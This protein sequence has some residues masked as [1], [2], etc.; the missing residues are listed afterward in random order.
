DE[1][2]YR[3]SAGDKAPLAVLVE[4]PARVAAEVSLYDGNKKLLAKTRGEVGKAVTTTAAQPTYALVR[5]L[6]GENNDDTYQISAR[7]AAAV[8]AAASSNGGAK[9]LPSTDGGVKPSSSPMEKKK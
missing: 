1:D 2:W 7:A 8:A 5:V 6:S 3:I 9:T 4:V